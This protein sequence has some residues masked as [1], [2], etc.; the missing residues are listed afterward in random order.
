ME[1]VTEDVKRIHQGNPSGSHLAHT[2]LVP[3]VIKIHNR[4]TNNDRKQTPA[5]SGSVE[6][7]PYVPQTEDRGI[8]RVQ[9]FVQAQDIPARAQQII[10]ASWRPSTKERYD[11]ILTRW[12]Q[13]C[14]QGQIS[15]FH[16]NVKDIISF[17]SKETER[18]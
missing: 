9:R 5:P 17:L 2:K 8:S 14:Y 6:E 18:G 1:S 13:F 15:C 16:P 7:T 4:C 11:P 3:T 12:E 10:M